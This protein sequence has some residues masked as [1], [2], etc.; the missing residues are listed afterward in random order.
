MVNNVYIHCYSNS[1]SI[2]ENNLNRKTVYF[3]ASITKP[4][5]TFLNVRFVICMRKT[6]V[7]HN[8]TNNKSIH[9][10]LISI[11]NYEPIQKSH[12]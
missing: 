1:I 11:H 8:K 2:R 5:Q 4:A 3:P 12:F 7:F 9:K 10:I 6:F